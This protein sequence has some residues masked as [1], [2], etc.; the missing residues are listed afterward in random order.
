MYE[1]SVVPGSYRRKDLKA[2]DRSI[3]VAA[4]LEAARESQ[5]ADDERI[6]HMRLKR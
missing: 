5:A 2:K 1:P 4:A 3:D 6:K